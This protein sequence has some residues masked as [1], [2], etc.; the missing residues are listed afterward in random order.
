M[1]INHKHNNPKGNDTILFFL[2]GHKYNIYH[3]WKTKLLQSFQNLQ[4]KKKSQN[5]HLNKGKATIVAN[6]RGTC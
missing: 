5:Q 4:I 3:V 1:E 2:N 6:L